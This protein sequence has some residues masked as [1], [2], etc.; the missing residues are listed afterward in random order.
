MSFH[1]AM[2]NLRKIIA[3]TCTHAAATP[4]I[5]AITLVLDKYDDED[6]IDF[7]EVCGPLRDH[8]AVRA[9][10]EEVERVSPLRS[11]TTP[12]SF[13]RLDIP[14]VGD[15]VRARLRRCVLAAARRD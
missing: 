8:A 7:F 14:T 4:A 9:A 3:E 6:M 1:E 5:S 13:P 11:F 10:L 2:S 15:D 12:P